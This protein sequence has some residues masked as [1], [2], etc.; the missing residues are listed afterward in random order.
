M[1]TP[2]LKYVSEAKV[3]RR[4]SDLERFTFPEVTERIYLSFLALAVMSQNKD[5]LPFVKS[6]AD[7]TLARGTFDSVRMNNN[8]LANMLAIVAGDTE[9]TKKLKNK[10]Q[11]QAMRQRQP[12]PVMALR[13]Y[14][15]SWDEHFKNLTQLERSL[16]I[17]DANYKNVRRAVA[18]YTTLNTRTKPQLM[19]RLKQLL[20]SKLP[21]TDIQRKF[22]EL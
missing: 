2:F 5:T 10:D 21:N 17:T 12:V 3:I 4:H 1:L 13:R 14:L 8:D 19:A 16:N 18:N 11:A 22:K 6:Y 15:R 20:Q 9:I 7:E